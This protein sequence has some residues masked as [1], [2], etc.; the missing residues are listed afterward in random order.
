MF[1]QHAMYDVLVDVDAERLR[2]DARNPWTAE[3]RIARLELDD[4]LDQALLVRASSGRALTRTVGGICDAPRPDGMRGVSRSG[5][6]WRPFGWARGSGRGPESA[7]EPF[8]QP[9]AGRPP[10]TATKHDELLLEQEILRDHPRTPPGPH[11]FAITNT[12]WSSVS[13]SPS[14]ASQRRSDAA[15]RATLPNLGNQR[16]NCELETHRIQVPRKKRRAVGKQFALRAMERHPR[17]A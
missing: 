8:A 2:E 1:R 16:E 3:P 17:S 14:C 13:R 15:S 5:R 10:A 12:R 4:G 9:Q 7:D 6:R 11:S